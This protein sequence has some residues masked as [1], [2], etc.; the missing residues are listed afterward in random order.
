MD[1]DAALAKTSTT[2]G[3]KQATLKTR[4]SI[5][6]GKT[7]KKGGD[8]DGDFSDYAAPK[9]KKAA[10]GTT[11]KPAPLRAKP[12]PSKI[13]IDSEDEKP[14]PKV[15]SKGAPFT[16][17]EDDEPPAVVSK[18]KVA[19]AGP[20]KAATLKLEIASEDEKPKTK[21]TYKKAS[22]LS[23]D[24]DLDAVVVQKPKGKGKAV[25]A[26]KNTPNDD[27]K[28][29]AKGKAKAAATTKRKRCAYIFLID[30]LVVLICPF[31][32]QS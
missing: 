3:K 17:S 2:K 23:D 32:A 10:S 14:K 31:S 20:S 28:P 18:P 21:A 6:S 5:G 16:L 24:D 22:V 11:S 19:K 7:K 25:T 1:A 27:E 9:T 13:E 8:E 4:K 30:L 12:A 29:A 26:K 15:Q